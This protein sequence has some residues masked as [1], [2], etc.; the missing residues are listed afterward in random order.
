MRRPDFIARQG[1]H[2]SGCLGA[3]I[4]RIMAGET[5]ADNAKAIALLGIRERQQVLDVGTGHGRSLGAI[6]DS[7]RGVTAT[8]IDSSNVMLAIA[9]KRNRS[10]M[11]TGCV[12][13]EKASSDRLPFTDASFD[14]AMAVHTLY[15]WRPAEPHLAEIARVLRPQGHF[16]LGFRPAE[17]AAATAQFPATVYTFRTTKEVEALLTKSGF[18]IVDS[19]RRDE[20]GRSLVWLRAVRDD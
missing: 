10:L 12:R 13:L 18:A 2:P 15:F 14:A 16:V 5:A 3:I 20:P 1:A 11:R 17:D 4:G 8:G 19:V 7:A 6:A 9:A